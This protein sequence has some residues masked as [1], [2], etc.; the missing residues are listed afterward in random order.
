MSIEP[1]EAIAEEVE[2]PAIADSKGFKARAGH[3][4]RKG[5]KILLHQACGLL[6]NSHAKTIVQKGKDPCL[7]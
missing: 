5:A 6:G 3:S 7:S 4:D 1:V 2:H